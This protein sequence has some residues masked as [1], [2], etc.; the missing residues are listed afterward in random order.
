MRE[1]S[2]NETDADAFANERTRVARVFASHLVRAGV[3]MTRERGRREGRNG[4]RRLDERPSPL[5]LLEGK[6]I[7]LPPNANR[8]M[9]EPIPEEELEVFRRSIKFA[10]S[11]LI[12]P[13]THPSLTFCSRQWQIEVS[14]AR[15]GT[16]ARSA[17]GAMA[18][19]RLS[20]DDTAASDVAAAPQSPPPAVR[21][22]LSNVARSP[23]RAW[24]E[25][26]MSPH[27]HKSDLA[28]GGSSPGA[29]PEST[30]SSLPAIRSTKSSTSELSTVRSP[31]HVPYRPLA[32]AP[33][34]PTGEKGLEAALTYYAAGIEAEHA[35]QL[36][37]AVNMYSKAFRLDDQVDKAYQRLHG[38]GPAG[39]HRHDGLAAAGPA[40]D[41]T[42]DDLDF[43]FQ[44]Q[45]HVGPD[46]NFAEPSASASDEPHR[47]SLIHGGAQ[48]HTAILAEGGAHFEPQEENEPTPLASIP[49]EV[50]VVILGKLGELGDMAGIG[51]FAQT[52]KKA[53]LLSVE[54]GVWKC[55]PPE[56]SQGAPDQPGH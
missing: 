1:V 15:T 10:S 25:G 42:V 22:R 20:N 23:E 55:A 28:G 56:H 36:S 6:T 2:G 18:L 11:C 47:S 53:F 26:P 50:L 33:T 30:T 29:S 40:D 48:L 51:R 52:C 5:L 24:R 49:D 19:G 34:P 4:C 27:L 35:H 16:Q 41:A 44:R 17:A 12:S 39:I 46:Y 9:S 21:R 45:Y 7:S 3:K 38:G 43:R 14:G 8:T 32:L 54:Q 13:L 31:L 37:L